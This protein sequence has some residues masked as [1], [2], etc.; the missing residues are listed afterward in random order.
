M[1]KENDT[2]AED[3]ERFFQEIGWTASLVGDTDWEV[4]YRGDVRDW[5]FYVRMTEYWVFF[6]TPV[7]NKIKDECRLNVYEHIGLLNYKINLAKY[8][9]NATFGVSLGVELPRENL[10]FSS[11]VNDALAALSINADEQYLELVNLANDPT[12]VSSLRTQIEADAAAAASTTP[13][14][15]PA[16]MPAEDTDVDWSASSD[17]AA[18][19]SVGEATTPAISAATPPTGET[20]SPSEPT[21]SVLGGPPC[22]TQAAKTLKDSLA[23]PVGATTGSRARTG[24]PATAAPIPTRSLPC[25]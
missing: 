9:I 13:A 24:R 22:Q 18:S 19:P 2:T 25:V 12:R 21:P 23:I 10:K 1:A 16:A 14:A 8:S 4:R 5:I 7:L 3:M 20:A 17:E 6:Y 11:M 15:T